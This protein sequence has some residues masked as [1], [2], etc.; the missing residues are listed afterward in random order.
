LQADVVDVP[1]QA[2]TIPYSGT[3]YGLFDVVYSIALDG[4]D[5]LNT[6]T[7]RVRSVVESYRDAGTHMRSL[8]VSGDL[9]DAYPTDTIADGA[10]LLN[11]G[12]DPV[13]TVQLE[14]K[15]HNGQYRR[16]GS[17]LGSFDGLFS[18]DGA[19][20]YGLTPGPLIS[21]NNSG[22]DLLVTL[23]IAGAVQPEER[24]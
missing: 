21:F 6:Y 1:A 13:E 18:F 23:T 9:S 5:D 20:L 16:D 4:T 22:E 12:V 14:G 19:I 15:R 17:S 3:S 10:L 24:I 7:E 2:F 11:V 8:T